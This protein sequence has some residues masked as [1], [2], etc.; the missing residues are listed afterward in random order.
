[1]SLHLHW[2]HSFIDMTT[3]NSSG[4]SDAALLQRLRGAV[5]L[6]EQ[7]GTDH[8]LLATLPA[9]DRGRLQ[10]AVAR[11]YHP[12]PVAR[13]QRLKAAERVRNSEQVQREDAVLDNTG[14]RTL[15]RKPVF[16]T[17]NCFPPG[18]TEADDLSADATSTMHHS[19]EPQHCYVCKQKYSAIHHFYDQLCPSCADFNFAKRME[20]A[21]LSGRVALLTGGRVKIGYQAGLKLLRAGAQLIVTTRFPHD[22]A[23]RY[24]REPDFAQ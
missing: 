3:M 17:P 24:S 9:D 20:L 11:V 15:R 4:E 19:L 2:Q 18:Q 5:E 21:D 14:I 22:S 23:S 12:D 6:L 1:M 13:R 16:S 10:R 8:S 7:I